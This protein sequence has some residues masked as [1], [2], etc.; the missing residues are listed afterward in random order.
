VADKDEKIAELC[1]SLGI[2]NKSVLKAVA[3]T[4]RAEFVGS[5]QEAFAH[6]DE[7]LPIGCGQTISQP[8]LVA[9]MTEL[10]LG[11]REKIHKVLEIGT[12]SGYQSAILSHLADEV[13]TIERI[14]PLC[15][16]V[17]SR[18]KA[19]GLTNIKIKYGDGYLGWPKHAPYDGIIVTA[20]AEE[21]PKTL[22]E[23]MNKKGGRMVIPVGE[24]QRWQEL[25]LVIRNDS[26]YE[27]TTYD[28][29]VFVPMLHGKK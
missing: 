11:D 25:Q 13:Y 12:G 10:L 1:A 21:V 26:H 18:F 24:Q 7:A 23:Q 2:N 28:S 27:V 19:L 14:K 16:Q 17:R 5:E 20:A 3:E 9:S 6:R 15:D 8:S 29:V 4:P 22:M